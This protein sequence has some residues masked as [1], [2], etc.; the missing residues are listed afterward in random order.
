[1]SL[2]N[3][4]QCSSANWSNSEPSAKHSGKTRSTGT[5][6]TARAKFA[7]SGFSFVSHARE[8]DEDA[9]RQAQNDAQ[10]DKAKRPLSSFPLKDRGLN[11]GRNATKIPHKIKRLIC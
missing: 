2:K 3:A 5:A 7:S 9:M 10:A 6:E 8:C 4:A 11:L 1:V